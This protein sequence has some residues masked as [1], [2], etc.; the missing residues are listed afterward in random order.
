MYRALNNSEISSWDLGEIASILEQIKKYDKAEQVYI[1]AISLNPNRIELI[2][3]Y[4][5]CLC[6]NNQLNKAEKNLLK[7][8]SINPDFMLAYYNLGNIYY[9]KG[10]YFKAL[11]AFNNALQLNPLVR[12]HI[13]I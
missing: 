4:A 8:I 3:S 6:K 7:V 11:N 1:R 13:I 12:I 2:Y 10:E 5:L 9:K